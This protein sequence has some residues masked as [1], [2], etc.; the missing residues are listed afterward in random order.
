MRRYQLGL[1]R[2]VVVMVAIMTSILPMT[3]A[4]NYGSIGLH[5]TSAFAKDGNN[6]GGNGN[7]G[8]GNSGNGNGNGNGGNGNSGSNGNSNSHS[9]SNSSGAASNSSKDGASSDG[10]TATGPASSK[11]QP[12]D[13]PAYAGAVGPLSVHHANGFTE[14]ISKGNYVMTDPKGRVVID[15]RARSDDLKRLKSFDR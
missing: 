3:I 4:F 1:R 9:S 2:Y 10:N 11:T 13:D 7:G 12:A 8:N 15:R 5:T 6:G 14:S